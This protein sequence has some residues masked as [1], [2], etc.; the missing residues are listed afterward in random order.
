MMRVVLGSANKKYHT[1]PYRTVITTVCTK[2]EFIIVITF[3]VGF[4]SACV[5]LVSAV[6]VIIENQ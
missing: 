5:A 6:T 1:I 4:G 2:T 3:P